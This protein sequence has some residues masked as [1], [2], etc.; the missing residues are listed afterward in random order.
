MENKI[1]VK[2]I[3]FDKERYNGSYGNVLKIHVPYEFAYEAD[4][5]KPK[6]TLIKQTVEAIINDNY[7]ELLDLLTCLNKKQ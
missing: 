2:G 5:N 4:V 1:Q 3:S 7:D 6:F